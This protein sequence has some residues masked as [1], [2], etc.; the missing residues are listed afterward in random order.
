MEHGA[1]IGGDLEVRRSARGGV[2]LRG[3]FP[4]RATAVLSDGGRNG[5]PRKERFAPRAFSYRVEREDEDI[6]L[7]VGH[8]FDKPLAS[9]KTGT[10]AIRDDGEAVTF[11]AEVS[12]AIAETTHGRDALAMLR[13]GLAVGISPGFRLPPKR[14]VAEPERFEDE[15][16]DPGRGMHGAIIRTITAALLYELSL[17]T[18]PAYPEAAVEEARHW[19]VPTPAVHPAMRWR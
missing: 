1:L 2:S 4:Y 18:M 12:E 11:E 19:P 5:R 16:H 9:R 7:L 6:H 8:R 15:P 17:V 14:A 13:S 10:L 3:R